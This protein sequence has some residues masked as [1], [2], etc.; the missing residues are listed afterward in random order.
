[1]ATY[2]VRQGDCL[3]SIGKKFGLKWQAIY[4]H[5]DN[6]DFKQKRP[7][8]NIIYPGDELFIPDIEEKV[9]TGAPENRH[10]F[11]VW[12]QTAKLRL[13]LQ[14]NGYPRKNEPFKLEIANTEPI[15]GMTDGDGMLETTIPVNTKKAK[16][17]VGK[18]SDEFM[19]NTSH[20][21]PIDEI[22]GI[23]ARLNNLGFDRGPVDDK[24]GPITKRAVKAFQR[25]FELTVDGN[26][27][28]ITQK[29]L[30]RIYSTE[31]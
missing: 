28:P 4:D 27:G 9:E 15:E 12:E 19:L 3:S 10:R 14:M 17:I 25:K 30:K 21:D 5:P 16:L 22:S 26:P 11:R 13:R 31:E 23:Q 18:S 29:K 1:M 7:N 24:F 2:T 8:P 6:A 20:L